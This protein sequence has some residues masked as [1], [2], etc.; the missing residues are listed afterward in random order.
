[1]R[2][3]S[4]GCVAQG[5][6]HRGIGRLLGGSRD[7]GSRWRVTFRFVDNGVEL[8]DHQDYH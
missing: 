4:G 1:M 7:D 3:W 8:V 2:V 6:G 5:L